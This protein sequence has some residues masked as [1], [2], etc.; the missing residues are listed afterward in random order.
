MPQ[1]V[2]NLSG[3]ILR[4]GDD[5]GK[6]GANGA[7]RHAVELRRAG[8]LHQRHTHLFLDGPQSHCAVRAHAGED[9]ADAAFLP[10]VGERAKKEIDRE[11]QTAGCRRIEQVQ[12]TVQNGHVLVGGDHIDA[13]RS[14]PHPVFDLKNLHCGGTPEEFVHDPFVCRVQMLDDHKGHAAVLGHLP[15]ELLQG[16]Q[17]PGGG[18]NADN[19]KREVLRLGRCVF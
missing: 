6:P 15:Q 16:L 18:A 11:S 3:Q 17:P 12:H 2:D 14:D 7:L 1:I 8:V 9:D 19:R 4:R 13:I 10:V 5:V